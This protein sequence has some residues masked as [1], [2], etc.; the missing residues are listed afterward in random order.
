MTNTTK[1]GLNHTRL[2]ADFTLDNNEYPRIALSYFL[3]L[4]IDFSPDLKIKIVHRKHLYTLHKRMTRVENIQQRGIEWFGGPKC[5]VV[6]TWDHDIENQNIP[7]EY[8]CNVKKKLLETAQHKKQ[9]EKEN[10]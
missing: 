6:T 2:A 1:I 3:W 10:S 8:F 7:L 4:C 9:I 5:F